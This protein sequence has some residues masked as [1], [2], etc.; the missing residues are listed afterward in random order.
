MTPII[1]EGDPFSTR[2]L[3]LAMLSLPEVAGVLFDKGAT[4]EDLSVTMEVDHRVLTVQVRQF[5]P[6]AW[7]YTTRWFRWSLE[8]MRP[9]HALEFH[10]GELDCD[11]IVTPADLGALLALI[12]EHTP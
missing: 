2:Q 9:G 10:S 3:G 5:L 7:P 6:D 12:H 4:R 11:G 1:T 8:D